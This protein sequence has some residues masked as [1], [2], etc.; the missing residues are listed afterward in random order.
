VSVGVCVGV[1]VD[2]AVLVGVLV[3]VGVGVT[4]IVWLICTKMSSKSA[5]VGA[6]K[7]WSPSAFSAAAV[8]LSSSE[9]G[10]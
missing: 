2:V 3:P 9:P 5:E 1:L 8:L 10:W 4:Q 6:M 7:K